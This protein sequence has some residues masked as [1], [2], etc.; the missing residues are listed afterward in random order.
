MQNYIFCVLA[1]L[2]NMCQTIG[3]FTAVNYFFRNQAW[4]YLKRQR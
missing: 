2:D 4:I 3:I 1:W